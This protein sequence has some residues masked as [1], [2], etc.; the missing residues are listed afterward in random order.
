MSDKFYHIQFTLN[1]SGPNFPIKI[2]R[3]TEYIKQEA[4]SRLLKKVNKT[5]KL[6]KQKDIT[7]YQY[8][9]RNT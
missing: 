8:Q 7:N 1:D 3:L 6:I 5:D 4:K 9:L 2:Q